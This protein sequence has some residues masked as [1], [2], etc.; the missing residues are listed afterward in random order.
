MERWD[1]MTCRDVLIDFER[2]Q[3]VWLRGGS[4]FVPLPSRRCPGGGRP[5]ARRVRR[6]TSSATSGGS[7]DDGPGEPEPGL[8]Q[9]GRL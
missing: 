3:C 4:A 5:R 2:E 8:A 1:A 7:S 9:R 6:K